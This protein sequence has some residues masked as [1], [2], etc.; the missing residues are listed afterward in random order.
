MVELF[1]AAAADER[2]IAAADGNADNL[3]DVLRII[4]PVCCYL[5]DDT[6]AGIIAL[7]LPAPLQQGEQ[8]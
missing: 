7:A 6:M 1:K 4:A 3:N 2:V 5:G 8:G